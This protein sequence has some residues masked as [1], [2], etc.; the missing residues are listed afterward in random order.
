MAEGHR[1]T[2]TQEP[3]GAKDM[4]LAV[5]LGGHE[6]GARA[7]LSLLAP[8]LQQPRVG[9]V[10]AF[11]GGTQ[12][13]AVPNLGPLQTRSAHHDERRAW[14]WGRVS[15]ETSALCSERVGRGLAATISR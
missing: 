3:Q 5:W 6:H 11:S 4:S 8:L 10:S 7:I 9:T 15:L 1:G 2:G 12:L 14:A 13:F